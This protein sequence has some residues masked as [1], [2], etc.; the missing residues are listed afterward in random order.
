MSHTKDESPQTLKLQDLIDDCLIEIF[1]YLSLNDLVRIVDCDKRFRTPARYVFARRFSKKRFFMDQFWYKKNG[2][3]KARTLRMIDHFG[4]LLSHMSITMMKLKNIQTEEFE[5]I[6]LLQQNYPSVESFAFRERDG[7]EKN[8]RQFAELNP[9]IR[10]LSICI[11][12]MYVANWPHLLETIAKYLPNLQTFQ[13][14]EHSYWTNYNWLPVVAITIGEN[15]ERTVEI[16]KANKT[17]RTLIEL[18]IQWPEL[19][20][21]TFPFKNLDFESVDILGDVLKCKSLEK[22]SICYRHPTTDTVF[23]GDSATIKADL[24]KVVALDGNMWKTKLVF[25][26]N[27]YHRLNYFVSFERVDQCKR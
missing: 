3:I 11:S 26:M 12:L 5:K 1:R 24:D 2:T 14:V 20:Q 4:D 6:Q 16:F 25:K 23:S 17:T 15:D 21:I 27:T 10:S 19:K 18:V 9:Q 22:L 8:I 7:S 13:L